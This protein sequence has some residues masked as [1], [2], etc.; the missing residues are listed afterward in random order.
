MFIYWTA[1][2]GRRPI[3]AMVAQ[4]TLF[5][6]ARGAVTLVIGSTT[7]GQVTGVAETNVRTFANH[8]TGTGHVENTG[9]REKIALNSGQN[10]VSEVVFTDVVSTEVLQNLY[11]AGD[12]VLLEYRTGN[13]K[14]ACLAASWTT[15]TAA[16]SSLG[17]VQVRVTST[18]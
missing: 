6:D 1:P 2:T 14:T 13:T 7:W 5:P 8:W 18:L 11:R 9:D 10:M 4:Q 17:Y 12:S 16:F 15:Y 3:S